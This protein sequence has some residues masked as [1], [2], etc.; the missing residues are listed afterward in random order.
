MSFIFISMGVYNIDFEIKRGPNSKM[1]LNLCINV[2]FSSYRDNL[3]KILHADFG[4]EG[5]FFIIFFQLEPI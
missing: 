3:N 1:F 5:M 2:F 4:G